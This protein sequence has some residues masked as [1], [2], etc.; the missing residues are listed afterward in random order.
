MF[1]AT[2]ST[3]AYSVRREKHS[4]R[5]RELPHQRRRRARSLSRCAALLAAPVTCRQETVLEDRGGEFLG[6]RPS[7]LSI[8][9]WSAASRTWRHRCGPSRPHDSPGRCTADARRA[10][11]QA[12]AGVRS[13][14]PWASRTQPFA[15]CTSS[16]IT[17]RTVDRRS[18][19]DT[20][21][22]APATRSKYCATVNEV[23]SLALLICRIRAAHGAGS[24][25]EC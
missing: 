2:V 6:G 23:P 12:R 8:P 25:R 14:I 5:L 19:I 24:T 15:V 21:K 3:K 11:D 9:G 18:V 17:G 13:R 1:I 22:S 10:P 16:P 7:A 4:D 20:M